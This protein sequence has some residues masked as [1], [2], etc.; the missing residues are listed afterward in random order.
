MIAQARPESILCLPIHDSEEL[1]G[2]LYL[3][4]RNLPGVFSPAHRR[5]V[6]LMVCQLPL[7]I[8]NVDRRET[9]SDPTDAV[10]ISNL[11]R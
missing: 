7:A 5:L 6:E 11:S 1:V 4:N 9:A 3:E 2:V 10:P 8:S